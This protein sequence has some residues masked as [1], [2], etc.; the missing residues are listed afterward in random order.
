MR[1]EQLGPTPA[2]IDGE[3][4][5][6]NPGETDVRAW[7]Q[8]TTE[9]RKSWFGRLLQGRGRVRLNEDD[10]GGDPGEGE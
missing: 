1:G 8:S 6:E 4:E 7:D 10:P 9:R 3:R 2:D 5:V